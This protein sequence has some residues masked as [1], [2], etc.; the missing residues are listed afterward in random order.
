MEAANDYYVRTGV[1]T[2]GAIIVNNAGTWTEHTY[3][4]THLNTAGGAKTWS[5]VENIYRVERV[6]VDERICFKNTWRQV[7]G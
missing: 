1:G 6:G 5:G 4:Q 7:Y 2:V 3:D